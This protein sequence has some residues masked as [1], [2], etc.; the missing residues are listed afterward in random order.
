MAPSTA[1]KISS[2]CI[3]LS[4]LSILAST[5]MLAPAGTN[6]VVSRPTDQALHVQQKQD[7]HL[8]LPYLEL[9]VGQHTEAGACIKYELQ[10]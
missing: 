6:N 4:A 9:Q 1:S 7:S 8:F 3:T 5:P 10:R 2:R